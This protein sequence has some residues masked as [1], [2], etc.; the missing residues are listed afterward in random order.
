[1]SLARR[2]WLVAALLAVA[3]LP[4]V[5]AGAAPVPTLAQV[6]KRVGPAVVV[7]RTVERMAP[8]VGD[9]TRL[10][11]VAG[12]GSG[13]FI[14]NDGKVLTAAHVVQAAEAVA[15]DF[16]GGQRVRARVIASDQPADVALLQLERVPPGVVPA[17]LGDS[18]GAEV[19]DGVFVVG[20]P[21]GI[22]HTLTVGHLSARRQSR[23]GYGALF[24]A[25]LFQTDAAINRGNSGG[26]MFNL[27]GEVIGIVSHIVSSSGGSEG[28]G[29]V[30]TSNLARRL[31]LEEPTPW[32][33]LDGYLL[34][35]EQA[36]LLNVPPP[37]AGLLVQRVA[38]GSPAERLGVRGGSVTVT[39]GEESLILGGDVILAVEGVSLAAPSAQD[40]IRRRLA[41]ARTAGAPRLQVLRDGR[42]LDLPLPGAGVPR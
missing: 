16:P 6:F 38:R 23:G 10:A 20:A 1:V 27:D 4:A 39:L 21:L 29:F 19:G 7:V 17:R 32:S 34:N 2:T 9:G 18:D 36:R 8:A 33:G 11:A 30:V 14:G 42:I 15:V 31:L 37:G 22:S 3:A 24:P 25:E 35:A 5:G 26:P 13:V 41:A 12:T 40:E 28:L